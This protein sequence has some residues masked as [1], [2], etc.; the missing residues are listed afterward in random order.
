MSLNTLVDHSEFESGNFHS[1][2]VYTVNHNQQST[3]KFKPRTEGVLKLIVKGEQVDLLIGI[4]DGQK[5]KATAFNKE[6][7]IGE[8][9]YK[10]QHAV[11]F[12]FVEGNKD[13]NIVI[14]AAN[15]T[16]D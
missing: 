12:A 14:K 3:I 16:S 10:E 5:Y 11:A 8:K 15:S 9:P 2:D 1:A 4:H 6:I 13:L 7:V